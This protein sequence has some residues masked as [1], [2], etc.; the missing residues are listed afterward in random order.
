ML[1]K[2]QRNQLF[3]FR[4]TNDFAQRFDN[5][6]DRL[7]FNRSDVCRYITKKFYLDHFN[8]PEFFKKVR[9]EMY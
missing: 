4:T 6:C 9:D 3:A 2:S 5:L 8:N 1:T 7:G